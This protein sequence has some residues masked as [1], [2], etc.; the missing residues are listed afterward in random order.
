[1]SDATN[2][3][4]NPLAGMMGQSAGGM[5]GSFIG[6]I[7]GQTPQMSV[8]ELQGPAKQAEQELF[9]RQMAIANGQAPTPQLQQFQNA[10]AAQA[11]SQRGVSNPALAMQ[12]ALKGGQQMGIEG[13]LQGQQNSDAM[14]AQLIAAQRGQQMDVAK[15]NYGGQVN[16]QNQKMNFV[17]GIGQMGAKAAMA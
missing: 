15:M 7:A 5:A 8:P 10:L 4:V 12:Q 3:L 1:M 14:M 11:A 2:M 13:A 6:G 16:A 17:S 9:A